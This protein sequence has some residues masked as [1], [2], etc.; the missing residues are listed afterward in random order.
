MKT[1]T[2]TFRL[3]ILRL[4]RS[5]QTLSGAVAIFMIPVLWGAWSK[6][7]LFIFLGT[8]IGSA[9]LFTLLSQVLHGPMSRGEL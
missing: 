1:N 8:I 7:T 9:A 5:L 2:S 6:P 3:T 4:L